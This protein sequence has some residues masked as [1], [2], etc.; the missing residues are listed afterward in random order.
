LR[1]LFSW[2]LRHNRD[3]GLGGQSSGFDVYSIVA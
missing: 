1:P 3:A 2:P